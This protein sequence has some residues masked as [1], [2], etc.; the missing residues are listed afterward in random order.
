[1]NIGIRLHD[2]LPGTLEQRLDYARAQGFTCVQ[3]AMGKAVPGFKM[4]AAPALLT[5]ELAG[6]VKKAFDDRGME[7]AVLGCYLKLTAAETE[8]RERVGE[9]YKAHLRFAR[10]IGA[11]VVG[12]ETSPAGSLGWGVAQ[13]QSEEGFRLFM[14]C[15]RPLVRCAEEEN[16]VLAI[17]PVCTDIISTPVRAQRMLEEMGSE[18]LRIILDAVNLILTREEE[19]ADAIIRDAIRRLGDRV[20]V[21]HMK[22][23]ISRP[24]QERPGFAP[25]GQGGMRYGALLRLAKERA[26]PMTLENTTPENAEQTRLY[27]E[28]LAAAL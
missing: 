17:E 24:D 27:L 12:T 22:D 15:L 8:E 5:K 19:R 21:L 25:C 2:T 14:E 18:H 16:A 13:I 20:E 6:Q 10:M 26:L 3:L 28:G 1:M 23:Y 9:I 11:R 7:C 4:D